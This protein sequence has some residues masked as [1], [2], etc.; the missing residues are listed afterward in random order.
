MTVKYATPHTHTLTIFI[1]YYHAGSIK[2]AKRKSFMQQIYI[3]PV[4]QTQNKK[5]WLHSIASGPC[6]RY[7][8]IPKN[9]AA[10]Q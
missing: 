10:R 2:R 8:Q 4:L 7:Q 3:F 5:D 1:H 6:T 9:C